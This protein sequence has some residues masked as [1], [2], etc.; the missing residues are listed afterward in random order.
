M[1]AWG[2]VH[3][4]S[5]VNI[6]ESVLWIRE[7]ALK[8]VERGVYYNGKYTHWLT[9]AAE[10]LNGSDI[11]DS[12]VCPD[13]LVSLLHRNDTT[14]DSHE[15]EVSIPKALWGLGSV[16]FIV[17]CII[18]AVVLSRPRRPDKYRVRFSKLSTSDSHMS[19]TGPVAVI[20]PETVEL[21]K[22]DDSDDPVDE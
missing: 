15:K 4:M 17:L 1:V 10:V 21:L 8:T 14:A 9:H 20:A 18:I 3:F 13:K 22:P 6:T 11:Q 12:H 2:C 19:L 7:H 16:V 5:S